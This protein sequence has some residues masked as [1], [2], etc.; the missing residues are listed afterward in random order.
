MVS[1][2]NQIAVESVYTEHVKKL[3]KFFYFKTLNKL[4]A[5][6]LVTQTFTAFVENSKDNKISIID[7]QDSLFEAA[8][9]IWKQYLENRQ[10]ITTEFDGTAE[11]FRTRVE[12]ENEA[13]QKMSMQDRVAVFIAVLPPRQQIIAA[14]CLLDGLTPAQTS[15]KINKSKQYVETILRRATRGIEELAIHTR[16]AQDRHA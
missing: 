7:L 13:I 11:D 10:L 3:Y 5:E 1:T 6:D 4:A 14:Y 8:Y 9:S 15:R 16:L 2:E 12:S